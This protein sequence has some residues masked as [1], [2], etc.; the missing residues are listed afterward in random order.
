MKPPITISLFILLA[1]ILINPAP[2]GSQ[3][4][5]TNPLQGNQIIFNDPTP[6]SQ[7]TPTGSRRGGA[8]RTC[9]RSEETLTALVPIQNQIVFGRTSADHPTLWFYLPTHPDRPM[10]IEFWLQDAK[11]NVIYTTQIALANRQPG[12]MSIAVPA[13]VPPL[14]VNQLYT[15]TLQG[16]CQSQRSAESSSLVVKGTI[17]RTPLDTTLQQQL[18]TATPL[19]QAKVYAAKG[20]WYDALNTLATSYRSNRRDRP[21]AEAWN[22]LLQQIGLE[23]LAE[24]PFISSGEDVSNRHP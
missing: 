22:T 6:P 13:T 11:D 21:I 4:S 5:T 3:P 1:G 7:G 19:E 2:S 24:K 14:A 10:T 15:W 16:S 23:S 20:I 9:Y 18:T 12:L 8:S 17:Q